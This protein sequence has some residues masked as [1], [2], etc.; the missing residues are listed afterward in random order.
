MFRSFYP[1]STELT[2]TATFGQYA[3]FY[4]RRVGLTQNKLAACARVNQSRLNKIV[5]ETIRDV[6]VNLLVNLCLVLGLDQVE[7]KDFLARKERAFSPAN[8]MHQCYLEL[9]QI[10]A[11]KE[12]DYRCIPVC[13]LSSVLDEADTYLEKRGFSTLPNYYLL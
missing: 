2:E 3:D 6:P 5:N 1:A 7:A 11:E 8:P 9:I 13:D 10:Y 12:L 4:T